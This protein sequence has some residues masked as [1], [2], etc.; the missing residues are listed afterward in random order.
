MSMGINVH[1]NS[2]EVVILNGLITQLKKENPEFK[3]VWDENATTK[4]LVARLM[5][6]NTN[7]AHYNELQFRG[8]A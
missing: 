4:K 3:K 7:I 6:A 5:K 2:D 1:L 8:E